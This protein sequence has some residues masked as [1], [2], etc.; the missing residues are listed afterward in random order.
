MPTLLNCVLWNTG[1]AFLLALVPFCAS[2]LSALQKR[3]AFLHLLWF[4]VLLRLIVPPFVQIPVLPAVP[5][6]VSD[7]A[8]DPDSLLH[9]NHVSI[10]PSAALSAADQARF[11]DIPKPTSWLSMPFALVAVSWTGTF[12]LL[13]HCVKR[14]LTISRLLRGS[15]D[16]PS[17][18]VELA[19][20]LARDMNISNVPRVRLVEG[21][22]SPS[23]WVGWRQPTL[24]LPRHLI[25]TLDDDQWSC[26]LAHELAHLLR[27]DHWFNLAAAGVAQLYWWNPM[28]WWAWREMQARQE[29]SCDAIAIAQAR[30]SRRVYAETL[31]QVVDSWNSRPQPQSLLC[32]GNRSVLSLTRRFEMIANPSVR[33]RVTAA[34]TVCL[35]LG[36]LSFV[37]LPVRAEKKAPESVPNTAQPSEV[38][39][40]IRNRDALKGSRVRLPEDLAQKVAQNPAKAAAEDKALV[41]ADLVKQKEKSRD[42][43]KSIML[44]MHMYHDKLAAFPPANLY[45]KGSKHP[46]SWRVA[47]L[48]YLGHT[49]LYDKYKMDEP[50]DSEA[51]K[52]V[53]A[54]V[55]SVFRDPGADEKSVNSAYFVLVGKLVEDDTDPAKLQTCFSSKL[56][57]RISKITDGTSPTLAVVEAKRDI[58]WT[59]PEDIS[60]DPAAKLP[61]LGLHKG[62]FYTAFGDGSVR[63]LEFDVVKE[64]GIKAFISP[65]GGEITP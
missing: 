55:P 31:L 37:G 28:A 51:N 21:L 35:A 54:E 22:I 64:A 49:D 9:G 11:Q 59:K 8:N 58:P 53:L 47:L 62:G 42:N 46:H 12:C 27:R 48:P 36:A 38:R 57:V 41:P 6:I 39:I 4:G 32:F 52:K 30:R 61:E 60:Y 23:L 25:D 1:S 34:V 65:A 17:G 44:A 33:P 20:R 56:G 15:L 7:E 2:R 14:G 50:W 43:L 5:I 40:R 45:S 24:L 3:P 10:V 63:Y 13:L 26:I 16:A 29:E 19:R 18:V